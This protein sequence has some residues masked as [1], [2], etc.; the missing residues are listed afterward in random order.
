MIGVGG[1]DQDRNQ[2]QLIT[3]FDVIVIVVGSHNLSVKMSF[4]KY[5]AIVIAVFMIIISLKHRM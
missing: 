5:I 1:S 4:N 3:D 2:L